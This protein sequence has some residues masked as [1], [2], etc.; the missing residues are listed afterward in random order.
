MF[1]VSYDFVKYS[2]L[3]QR[4][5][6]SL[7]KPTQVTIWHKVQIIAYCKWFCNILYTL[8]VTVW[9]STKVNKILKKK[10]KASGWVVPKP[11]IGGFC[12]CLAGGIS[13]IVK[14]ALIIKASD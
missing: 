6:H 9:K 1:F 4:S 13:S 11:R 12:W 14:M 2:Y 8:Q 10:N 3:D 5:S 7:Y